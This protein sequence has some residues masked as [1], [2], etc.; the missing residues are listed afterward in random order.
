MKASKG[1]ALVAVKQ[2]GLALSYVSATLKGDIDVCIAAAKQNKRALRYSARSLLWTNIRARLSVDRGFALWFNA[3]HYGS[4]K[5]LATTRAA[6]RDAVNCHL[7]YCALPIL[8]K[9]G[10]YQA[11]TVFMLI[12]CY[13]DVSEST[14]RRLTVSQGFLKIS[15]ALYDEQ[16]LGAD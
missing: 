3:T 10:P 13:A 7:I 11:I 5:Q 2:N 12:A 1:V 15:F 8:M 16:Y 14:K 9:N 6:G 4:T